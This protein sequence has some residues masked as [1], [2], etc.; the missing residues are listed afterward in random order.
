MFR[1]LHMTEYFQNIFS[2]SLLLV[3]RNSDTTKMFVQYKL[4]V[5]LVLTFDFNQKFAASL[6]LSSV[7]HSILDF[8]I[9]F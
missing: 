5:N 6:V 4:T 8:V 7:I 1:I 2:Q 3:T 9:S